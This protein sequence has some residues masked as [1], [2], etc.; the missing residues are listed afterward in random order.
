M[1]TVVFVR[2]NKCYNLYA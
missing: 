1:Q 2:Y